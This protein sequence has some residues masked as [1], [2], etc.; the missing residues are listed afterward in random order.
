MILDASRAVKILIAHCKGSAGFQG[1]GMFESGARFWVF[2]SGCWDMPARLIAFIL[3]LTI[4]LVVKITG[5]VWID[6]RGNTSRMCTVPNASVH[7]FFILNTFYGG[8]GFF[9]LPLSSSYRI[10]FLQFHLLRFYPLL[11]ACKVLCK[12]AITCFLLRFSPAL[13]CILPSENAYLPKW[14]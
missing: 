1:S 5:I 12:K 7:L 9:T 3:I 11:Y 13:S 10:I 8:P 14:G 4:L 2:A 6:T